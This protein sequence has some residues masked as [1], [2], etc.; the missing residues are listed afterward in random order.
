SAVHPGAS[1]SRANSANG[2]GSRPPR[3]SVERLHVEAAG[4]ERA[5]LELAV[6]PGLLLGLVCITKDTAALARLGG[7][8]RE[9]RVLHVFVVAEPGRYAV[10]DARALVD[11]LLLSSGAPDAVEDVF[12]ARE[13]RVVVAR[14]GLG[15]RDGRHRAE[16][17]GRRDTAPEHADVSHFRYTFPMNG[18]VCGRTRS[19]AAP[20]CLST[21]VLQRFLY[22]DRC[23]SGVFLCDEIFSRVSTQRVA[24]VKHG[25]SRLLPLVF[26]E[27][28]GR[29]SRGS[30]NQKP[31]EI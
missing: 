6:Q 26:E 14:P 8:L 5:G 27:D 16:Q 4:L 12:H 3:R 11:V 13:G 20:M 21:R 2:K 17:E 28:A 24:C 23:M 10:D 7:V 9:R 30:E 31:E 15:G 22:F 18:A 29:R 25:G 1:C 19:Y